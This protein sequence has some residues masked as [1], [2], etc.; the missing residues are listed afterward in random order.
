MN[1]KTLK[2]W[3]VRQFLATRTNARPAREATEALT[4]A[5]FGF[6][7]VLRWESVEC[8]VVSRIFDGSHVFAEC[9]AVDMVRARA[10]H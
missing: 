10:G 5:V 7:V 8:P 9:V 4:V 2:R 3:L 6:V 1:K